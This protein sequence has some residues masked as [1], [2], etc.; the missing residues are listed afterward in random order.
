MGM[1]SYCAKEFTATPEKETLRPGMTGATIAVD[2]E[3]RGRSGSASRPF[4]FTKWH[5]M[6]LAPGAP[7]S[8]FLR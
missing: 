5:D 2:C 8:S 7:P 1:H 6:E 3:S 4:Y